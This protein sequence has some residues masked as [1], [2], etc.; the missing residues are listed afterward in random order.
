[1]KSS[2]AIPNGGSL[3]ILSPDLLAEIISTA[4]DIA[5]HLS[6]DGKVMSVLV[7]EHHR[8]FGSLDG[9]VGRPLREM[10]TSESVQKF[11]R[12]MQQLAEAPEGSTLAIEITHEDQVNAGFPVR[13]A[14]HRLPGDGSVL[15]LG[16]DMRAIAEIQQKLVS[17]Q[18]ALEKDY[19]AQREIDTRY[20]V[21]MEMTRDAI[22]L[23]S[24]A[25]G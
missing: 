6:A 7:N 4:S 15:M 12:R 19:E 10:L 24:M 3:P 13:Y 11:D 21:L 5:L 20:R 14:L 2:N 16:R 1:M 9:W 18:L 8:S 25:T 17:V 23:V 22:L